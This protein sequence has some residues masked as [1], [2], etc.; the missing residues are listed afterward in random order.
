M[1]LDAQGG[2]PF[3]VYYYATVSILWLIMAA[4]SDVVRYQSPKMITLCHPLPT[5][6]DYHSSEVYRNQSH[7]CNM[8]GDLASSGAKKQLSRG[9]GLKWTMENGREQSA[10]LPPSRSAVVD[11][12]VSNQIA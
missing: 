2:L 5:G 7:A 10:P 12:I 6:M 4:T 8:Q 9:A 3:L 1:I 11:I